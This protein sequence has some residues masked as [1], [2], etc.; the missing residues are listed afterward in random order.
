VREAYLDNVNRFLDDC[1]KQ[2]QRAGVD[3]CL[4]NTSEPI[5]AALAAFL[6]KRAR[7]F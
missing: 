6:S 2:C 3:Y 7:G 1:K 4:L 5:D